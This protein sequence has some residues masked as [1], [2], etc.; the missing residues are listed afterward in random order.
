[1][2]KETEIHRQ[3]NDHSDKTR[4]GCFGP[5]PWHPSLYVG[6]FPVR[7]PIHISCA[8]VKR[9]LAVSNSNAKNTLYITG[10]LKDTDK[11]RDYAREGGEAMKIRFALGQINATVG[12]LPGNVRRIKDAA[13]RAKKGGAD[14]VVF[15]EMA[16]TGYPPEDL[17]LKPRFIEANIRALQEVAG[18][19]R[20]IAIVCGFV[21]R[22]DD[23]YNAAAVCG[24]GRVQAVYHK[25][26]LPNYGV[27]DENRYFQVGEIPLVARLGEH[28]IGVNVCEDIWHPGEPMTAQVLGGDAQVI[29]NIS[30]SPFHAGKSRQRERM[31]ATRAADNAVALVFCNL[32]GGQDELVFDGNSLVIDHEGT[33]L[34]RGKSFEED[35]VFADVDTAEVFRWRLHDARF[36]QGKLR[37]REEGDD[38]MIV[39]LDGAKGERKRPA[40]R[41]GDLAPDGPDEEVYRALVMGTR[42]YVRKNGFGKVVIGLSGG[43]DS[44]LVAAVAADALGKANVQTVFMPSRYSSAQSARDAKR[45]ARNLGVKYREIS[46]DETFDS[47]K[48]MMAKSF[49]GTGEDIAEENIQARI[50]GNILMALSNKF[51]WLVLTTGNKSETSVGYCTLYGD[52]AGGFAV[53]KDVPKTLVYRLCRHRNAQA[54]KELIPESI[55]TKAPSAELRPD[56]KDSDSLP[57]YESL[58]PILKMYVEQDKSFEQ[59][60]AE[61]HDP[62]TVAR[63]IRMVDASE[64]KRRQGPPGIKITPRAFGKDRRLPITNRYRDYPPSK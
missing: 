56:Q 63:V 11:D 57:P 31:L 47:Y 8:T 29:V 39:D 2:K 36:R 13:A 37:F 58:D 19:A 26:Y 23:V 33:V 49:R 64:Y 20:G 44:A 30:S 41:Q 50:R 46:I 48:A 52:M 22:T 16:V 34:A 51:G 6:K 7:N 1:M 9:S 35:L 43:V 60:A 28:A 42:D 4:P 17:L 12:D 24:A 54:K 61:G 32:V 21:D 10:A 5:G 27:F 59:I 38:L 53:I 18:A 3:S 14:V 55:L 15:P 45:L 25:M 40:L 62:E